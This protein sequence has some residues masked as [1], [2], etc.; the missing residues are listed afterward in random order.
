MSDL[1]NFYLM[2]LLILQRCRSSGELGV[3][4]KVTEQDRYMPILEWI[5][6]VETLDLSEAHNRDLNDVE[7]KI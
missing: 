5:P 3:L 6:R 2:L 4:I 7:T 1:L